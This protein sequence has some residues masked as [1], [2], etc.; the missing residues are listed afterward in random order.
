M[1]NR[2]NLHDYGLVLIV[3]GVLNLFMFLSTVVA[4]FVDGTMAESLATVEAELLVAVKVVLGVIGGLMGLLVPADIL[5]GLKAL[6]VS[7]NPNT[8]KGYITV[9]KV[10]FVMS[11][12]ATVSSIFPFFD[13]NAPIVDTIL[14]FANAALDAVVY[15]LFIKAAQA[16]RRDVLNGVE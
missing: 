12:I 3:L 6:K 9:A 16:V 13:A 1:Q 15:I 2:K 14:T 11:V 7:K 8:D 10:F 5:I 4:G